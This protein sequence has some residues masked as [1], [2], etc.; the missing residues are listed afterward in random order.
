[1]SNMNEM[2]AVDVVF[3]A[4]TLRLL[5]RLIMIFYAPSRLLLFIFTLRRPDAPP[6]SSL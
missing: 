1:M 4:G 2:S 3:R 6:R 5:R